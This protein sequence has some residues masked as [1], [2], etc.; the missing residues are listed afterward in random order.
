MAPPA[1]AAAGEVPPAPSGTLLRALIGT[2]AS[3]VLPARRVRHHASYQASSSATY[4]SSSAVHTHL[5]KRAASAPSMSLWSY[6]SASRM[7]VRGT[8]GP[9]SSPPT[10]STAGRETP[11]IAT[12]GGFTMGVK[13]V[14]PMPPRF[15]IEKL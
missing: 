3:T 10:G 6:V 15:E 11:R 1:A 13:P 4:G 7:I 9:A 5:R 12:S 14:P 2:H 8:N